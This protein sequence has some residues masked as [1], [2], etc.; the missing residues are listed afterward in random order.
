MDHPALNPDQLNFHHLRYFGV[1][2]SLA[3][4]TKHNK[5][6]TCLSCNVAEK[7][8]EGIKTMKVNKHD[9]IPHLTADDIAKIT[10]FCGDVVGSEK[11]MVSIRIDND[12][13]AWLKS[14]GPGYESRINAILRQMYEIS[15]RDRT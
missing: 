12:V 11:S 8:P 15:H 14:S 3:R 7:S 1:V 6:I 9:E 4:F 10:P 2:A 13:Y 5:R